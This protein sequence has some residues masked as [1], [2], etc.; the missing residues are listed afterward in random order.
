[1]ANH[2]NPGNMNQ[3]LQ[4][5][6][7]VSRAGT[8]TKLIDAGIDDLDALAKRDVD[9][10]TRACN[11]VRK[12]QAPAAGRADDRVVSIVV[13]DQLKKLIKWCRHMWM[14]QRNLEFTSVNRTDL[15]NVH[16]YYEML[17]SETNKADV[18]NFTD[19]TNRKRWFKTLTDYLGGKKGKGGVPI[20][21]VVTDNDLAGHPHLG[22]PDTTGNLRF[23]EEL[24]HRG[25]HS[26]VFHLADNREVFQFL[27]SKCENSM[28]WSFI[29]GFSRTM[30]GRPAWTALIK[31]LMGLGYQRGV[32]THANSAIENAFWDGRNR[33]FPFDVFVRMLRQ[34]FIDAGHTDEEFK[35]TKLLS[36]MHHP[37]IGPIRMVIARDPALQND[38]EGVVAFIREMIDD[39]NLQ[40]KGTPTSRAAAAKTVDVEDTD[41]EEIDS[42]IESNKVQVKS[43]KR[44]IKNL[45]NQI[46]KKSPAKATRS[47]DKFDSRNKTNKLT[48]KA[49]R[50]LSDEKK[51]EILQARKKA[52]IGS[53]NTTKIGSVGTK[54][55]GDSEP[56]DEGGVIPMDI[57]EAEEEDDRKLPA[58]DLTSQ[59]ATISLNHVI[60]SAKSKPTVAAGINRGI[61]QPPITPPAKEGPLERAHDCTKLN[62]N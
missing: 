41:L 26:G 13:E 19:K 4:H 32:K 36:S 37:Q 30:N 40:K 20:L 23:D 16:D 3:V 7:G 29:K 34:A 59:Q 27:R 12:G 44:K 57:N 1:M 17:N 21:Y 54:S 33:N 49:W 61:L 18:N 38:F 39:N 47:H 25:R 42:T 56:E 35:I 5:V 14:V 9:C 31:G 6:I 51:K 2:V 50:Q 45:R 52:G 43:L 24:M 62:S 58:V 11:Q 8:R 53:G 60:S 22:H 48:G 10:A 28:A 55:D 46:K 15:D